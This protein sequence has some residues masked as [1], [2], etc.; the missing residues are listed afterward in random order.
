MP[1]HMSPDIFQDVGWRDL[2]Y[3]L[4]ARQE[5]VENFFLLLLYILF[6]LLFL[7]NVPGAALLKAIYCNVWTV[8]FLGQ[9][10]RVPSIFILF[11][12]L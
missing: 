1:V 10:I 4:Y 3:F 11:F 9:L 2:S 8:G 7:L 6:L 5:I 12:T